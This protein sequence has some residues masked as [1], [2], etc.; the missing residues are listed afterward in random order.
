MA[1]AGNTKR[2]KAVEIDAEVRQVKS[3]VDGTVN[4]TLNL[5]E[6]CMPQAQAIMGWVR[7]QVR[8]VIALREDDN[9]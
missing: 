9:V 1:S 5:P 6:Y 2:V 3:M 7:E 4:V 8:V